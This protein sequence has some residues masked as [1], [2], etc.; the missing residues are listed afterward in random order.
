MNYL[1][2]S[3]IVLLPYFITDSAHVDGMRLHLRTAATN[4][5]IVHPAGDI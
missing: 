1:L 3:L 5:P 4:R 2:F